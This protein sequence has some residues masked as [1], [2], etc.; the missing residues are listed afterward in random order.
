[1]NEFLKTLDMLAWFPENISTFGK[2]L[3]DLF[4]VIYWISVAIFI[5]TFGVMAWFL[6]IYRH[7][8][9]SRGYNYHG[10]NIVEITWTILPTIL[11][12]GIGV[13]SDAIWKH[14]KYP[15][16][17]PK[18][19]VEILVL[20]KQFGWYFLYPGADG[21]FGRNA[22]TDRS[23]RNLMSPTNPFGIDRDDPAS[24]DDFVVENQFKVPVNAYVLVHGSSIDVLHSFFLPHARVKQDLIP[25]TWMKI[26]FNL[27]KTGKYELACAELCG[28][29]HYAMRAEYEVLSKADY[30]Q[31]LDKQAL[32]AAAMMAGTS[33]APADTTASEPAAE[34]SATEDEDVWSEE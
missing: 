18:G 23:A 21:T 33:A 13:Y 29:G 32:A 16:Q 22:Y 26:W 14:T 15:E 17:M 7:R 8:E 6:I 9:G 27:F 3:D 34:G 20:G 28:G 24:Q 4:I 25:G 11:F 12:F 31:W 19:D 1:M 30:D 2:E 10:N 5:L